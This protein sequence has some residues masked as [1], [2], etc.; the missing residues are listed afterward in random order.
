MTKGKIIKGKSGVAFYE[1]TS[2]GYR[3]KVLESNGKTIYKKAKGFATE[4]EAVENYKQKK[5]EYEDSIRDF[6]A[7]INKDIFFKDYIKYWFKN[8]FSPRVKSNTIIIGNYVVE[9]LI[10]PNIDYDLKINLVTASYLDE[11]ILKASKLTSSGGYT[12]RA[13]ISIAMSDAY[14]GGYITYNPFKDVK[15]Y[16][17]PKPKIRVLSEEQIKKFL[18]EA[19][20]TTWYLEILL[21]LFIGLRKGEIMGLKFNDFDIENNTVRIERQ[22]VREIINEDNNCEKKF[23]ICEN[24]PK[25]ENS[26]RSLRITDIILQELGKR[27]IIVDNFKDKYKDDYNDNNYICCQENGNPRSITGLNKT[28]NIICSKLS[29]P[30]ITVHGLRHICAT[31]LLE[32]GV[33]L[34]VIS[35]FLGHSSIHT[36]FEYYCEVMDEKDRI[37]GFMNNIFAAGENK[38]ESN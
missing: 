4:E 34:A 24:K 12:A 38:D 3:Y 37:L 16:S 11:I 25:T 29:L 10:L 17:R 18:V 2:W 6:Y 26:I 9:R 28:L 35:A 20:N 15:I 5:K 30:H 7:S 32:E 22:L 13:Y 23:I 1:Y 33:S 21:A 31:I 27:K 8:I 36:T 14:I 19:K